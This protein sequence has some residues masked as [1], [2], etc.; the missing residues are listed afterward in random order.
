[1]LL[2]SWILGEGRDDVL[3][4]LSVMIHTEVTGPCEA[5]NRL[6]LVKFKLWYLENMCMCVR[7]SQREWHAPRMNIKLPTVFWDEYS[8]VF[9][10][11]AREFVK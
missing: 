6:F 11:P 9:W 1:M 3:M 10:N 7:E 8:L 2:N 4:P 5:L